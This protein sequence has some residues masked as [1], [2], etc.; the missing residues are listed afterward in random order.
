MDRGTSEG[1]AGGHLLSLA[2]HAGR[3]A[4]VVSRHRDPAVL[5]AALR[6]A[7]DLVKGQGSSTS[8]AIHHALVRASA[9]LRRRLALL[10][11]NVFPAQLS[12]VSVRVLMEIGSTRWPSCERGD[13]RVPPQPLRL[14]ISALVL[15]PVSYT[16]LTLPTNREV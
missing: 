15:A 1:C 8:R 4:E 12:T 9:A 5:R 14:L 13:A 11:L 3:T 7:D 2:A 6:G 16:H 10:L